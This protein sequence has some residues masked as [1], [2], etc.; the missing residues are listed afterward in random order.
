VAQALEISHGYKAEKFQRM[1]LLWKRHGTTRCAACA[2]V[3]RRRKTGSWHGIVAAPLHSARQFVG[4]HSRLYAVGIFE[5]LRH[6]PAS[7]ALRV[8]RNEA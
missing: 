3:L 1:A 2:L 6:R 8:T 5:C 4:Q 7:M